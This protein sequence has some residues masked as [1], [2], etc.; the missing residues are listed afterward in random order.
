MIE[1]NKYNSAWLGL[2]AGTLTDPGWF[3]KSAS[4]RVSELAGYGFVEFKARLSDAPAATLLQEAGFFWVDAII[5]FRIGLNRLAA[6][7]SLE[8][9]ECV[10]AQIEP[11]HVDGNE[12]ME[13]QSERFLSLPGMTSELLAK[14]YEK[15]ANQLVQEEPS[16]CFRVL[17][18]GKTQGWF[19][20]KKRGTSVD[21]TLAMLAKGASATGA[22]LYHKAL[23]AY[24]NMG[25]SMGKAAFSVK[26]TPVL[27]IYSSLGAHFTQPE[28]VW[29]W[30]SR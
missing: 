11:F 6:T 18:G 17:L 22:H 16:S 20:G 30:I 1:V 2:K 12:M 14:R 4:E 9:Y 23:L 13:F 29:I 28:G 21:L 8:R 5:G 24:S 26:N 27:N 25:C 7:P 3:L 10:S 15:W 19:L